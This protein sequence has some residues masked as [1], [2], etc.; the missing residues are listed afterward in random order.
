MGPPPFEVQVF[1]QDYAPKGPLGSPTALS[2]VAVFN[3][4]GSASFTI[5]VDHPR[6]AALNARSARVR[7][8]YTPS[9]GS[10]EFLL[11]GRVEEVAGGTSAEGQWRTYT[12]VDDFSVMSDEILCWPVPD[13]AI[14][15]QSD[16][17]HVVTGPAETMLKSILAPNVTRDGI[18]LTIPTTAGLGATRTGSVRFHTPLE[19]LVPLVTSAG[20]GVRVEQV[21]DE[22][23][24]QVWAPATVARVLTQESNV[25]LKGDFAVKAPTV[26]RVVA[27]A[28]GEGE[29]RVFRSYEDATRETQWGLVLP[30]FLDARDVPADDPDL[31]DNLSERAAERLAE[32]APVA[33][34]S[35]ELVE[36]E[37]FRFGSA[38]HLGDVVSIQLAGDAPVITDRVREVAF[39]WTVADGAR[40]TPRVG[41]WQDDPT[42]AVVKRV[43]ALTR[44]VG[45]LQ[46][47]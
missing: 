46:R 13:A 19:R 37:G 33:S 1:D 35:C 38:F 12:V 10:P 6:F 36:S 41:E 25:V 4:V 29:D 20:I 45:N 11:S 43:T 30:V 2:G 15:A 47:S 17:Y 8:D 26:T 28:G 24:L 9:D 32:G 14:T 27:G 22:R 3:D 44:A 5:P 40:I 18:H 39:E 31:D 7:I 34:V 16:A 21:D 23:V 42:A